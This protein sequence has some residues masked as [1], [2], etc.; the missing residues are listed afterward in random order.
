[1]QRITLF[2]LLGGEDINIMRNALR[3]STA[4]PYPDE[5]VTYDLSEVA[6]LL[7]EQ[8][9]LIPDLRLRVSTIESLFG[10]IATD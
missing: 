7:Y 10:L 5:K 3:S 6:I 2:G 1:M 9:K 8:M 4:H